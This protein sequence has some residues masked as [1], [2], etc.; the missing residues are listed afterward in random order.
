MKKIIN[1]LFFILIFFIFSFVFPKFSYAD[2]SYPV[3]IYPGAEFI[4]G[5]YLDCPDQT[6][7]PC[8]DP[9]IHHWN[10]EA[11][12]V[13][14]GDKWKEA[15]DFYRLWAKN[16]NIV[17]Y[18]LESD[19]TVNNRNIY[20]SGNRG[21]CGWVATT[22]SSFPANAGPASAG[23]DVYIDVRY[24]WSNTPECKECLNPDDPASDFD[25]FCTKDTYSLDN[26]TAIS[27]LTS[28]KYARLNGMESGNSS[29]ESS[30]GGGV[31]QCTYPSDEEQKRQEI[32]SD[33]SSKYKF[34]VQDSNICDKQSCVN[35]KPWSVEELTI[36]N[37]TINDLPQCFIEKLDLS[38][39]SGIREGDSGNLFT[40][41]GE[42]ISK[43]LC[44]PKESKELGYSFYWGVGYNRII[45][46]GDNYKNLP[47]SLGGI[48]AHEMTH[49]YQNCGEV[50]QPN[51]YNC[52]RNTSWM[53]A[54]DWLCLPFLGCQNSKPE[55]IP[56]AYAKKMMDPLE[57]MAESVRLYYENPQEL[58]TI[59]PARYDFV[60]NNIMCGKEFTKSN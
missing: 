52:T 5:R 43:N 15:S 58:K 8:E 19:D 14:S 44:C 60:K 29:G 2:D 57:D 21:T 54:T 36:F 53:K 28:G 16:N 9:D 48:L 34:K 10:W 22:L 41:L 40:G 50:I 30:S 32:F 26:K 37:K 1:W 23:D 59:S 4:P 24:R 35:N 47:Y 17:I 51:V 12:L 6:K 25:K 27:I 18:E 33:L 3:P 13:I 42:E 49:A 46:C 39:I 31:N 7:N 55:E 38:G 45:F 11:Y 20:Y 56:T